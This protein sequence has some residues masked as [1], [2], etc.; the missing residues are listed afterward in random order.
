MKTF[1]WKTHKRERV[2]FKTGRGVFLYKKRLFVFNN[3]Y[4]DFTSGGGVVNLG[5]NNKNVKHAIA[6]QLRTGILHLSN[7][8]LNN[9]A[10][11]YA[12]ALCLASGF[13]TAFFTNSGTES[14]EAAIK[15][16]RKYFA[17]N[18]KQ[19]Y[20][21]ISLT[22]AFHGRTLGSLSATYNVKYRQGFEPLCEGFVFSDPKNIEE[23]ITE[24]TAAIILE[25]IQGEG[26]VNFL[27]FDT[28]EAIYNLCKKYKILLIFDEVQTGF[29][30]TGKLFSYQ[31]TKI[32]PD[33]ITCAKGIAN[34]IPFGA[35]LTRKEISD[36]IEEGSHGGTFGGNL[37]AVSSAKA[38]LQQINNNDFLDKVS[39]VA[40]YVKDKLFNLKGEFPDLILEVR[41]FGLMLGIKMADVCDIN[42]VKNLAVKERLLLGVCSSNIIRITPPLVIS[43]E[44]VDVGV[45]KLKNVLLDISRK[46]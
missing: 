42:E 26:G 2:N 11:G 43:K 9:L 44:E 18:D 37:I 28:I 36:C 8:Y 22:G 4:L 6:R 24:K 13:E 35:V 1:L 14:N 20:E 34:G 10:E 45:R 46:L 12:K 17:K 40:N 23:K 16:V 39:E 5:Y 41:G 25:P 19:K 30:R 27:G 33:I 3:K 32:K 15:L 29:G 31:H 21:I 7:Y 38:T